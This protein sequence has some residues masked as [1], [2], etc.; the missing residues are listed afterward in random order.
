MLLSGTSRAAT[1]NSGHFALDHCLVNHSS[2]RLC[3]LHNS[4]VRYL[5]IEHVVSHDGVGSESERPSRRHQDGRVKRGDRVASSK[6]R[7]RSVVAQS[8]GVCDQHWTH[9]ATWRCAPAAQWRGDVDESTAPRR[10]MV[11]NFSLRLSSF[12]LERSAASSWK[13]ENLLAWLSRRDQASE[14]CQASG[15]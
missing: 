8:R 10:G 5:R 2:G 11:R 7:S 1:D 9:W 4:L 3:R 6:T 13:E 12:F 14:Q 15:S